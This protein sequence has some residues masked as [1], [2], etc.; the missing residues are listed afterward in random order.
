MKHRVGSWE[1]A[2]TQPNLLPQGEGKRSC[3]IRP[4]GFF[5]R[6]AGSQDTPLSDYCLTLGTLLQPVLGGS[7]PPYLLS[8]IPG[9]P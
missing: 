4:I 8:R 6:M 1:L 3:H 7:V 9:T 5:R 2:G